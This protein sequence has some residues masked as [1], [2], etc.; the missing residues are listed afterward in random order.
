M[1]PLTPPAVLALL[2]GS[3]ADPADER[4]R[5]PE[6][7]GVL[8]SIRWAIS[9]VAELAVPERVSVRGLGCSRLS[10]AWMTCTSVG[11]A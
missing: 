5:L 8:L 10:K 1:L 2:A 11:S 9:R 3:R 4:G 6:M 7:P